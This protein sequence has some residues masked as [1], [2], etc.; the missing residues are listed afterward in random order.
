MIALTAAAILFVAACGDDDD[1][2]ASGSASAADTTAAA[3]DT[4]AGGGDGAAASTTAGAAGG[5][6]VTVTL[7]DYAFEDL[8]ASV[9]AGTTFTIDNQSQAELHEMVVIPKPAGETRSAEELVQLPEAELDA[10]FGSGEPTMVLLQPPGGGPVIPAVGDGTISEPGDYIV[11]CAI[12]TGADPDEYLDAP[13]SDG[14]PEV[15][16]GPPHFVQ[17][18]YAD[19][20]VE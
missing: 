8:P 5:E 16:G 10:L 18:M 13:P 4:T 12:P 15:E 20:T 1:D 7:V 9:P 2:D 6:T 14:P 17:G 3:T 19:L 11:I